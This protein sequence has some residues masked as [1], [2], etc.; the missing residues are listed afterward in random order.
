MS[1]VLC[2][3]HVNWDVTLHVDALPD[4]DGEARIRSQSQSG[5]GSAANVATALAT[6]DIPTSVLGSVGDDEHGRAARRKLTE[7]G[8]DTDQIMVVPDRPTT[9]KYLIVEATSDGQVMVFGNDGA[10]EAIGPTDIT[11]DIL[12]DVDHL[13][14][15]GQRPSTARAL[16]E[17][18]AT[19][20]IPISVD[21]GRRLADRDYEATLSAAD[22]VFLNGREADCLS[23]QPDISAGDAFDGATIVCKEGKDGA[24][25]YAGENTYQQEGYPVETVDTAGAGDAFAAGFL[26]VVLEGRTDGNIDYERALAVANACGALAT[27]V[28]GAQVE[29]GWRT[30]EQFL[31]D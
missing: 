2:A 8:V 18:A 3:G 13:H 27:T 21:P 29:V 7:C 31:P 14:L 4:P 1:R 28:E 6:L 5:G 23:I 26:A 20:G 19:I 24:T 10:N 30:V 9:V 17:Q 22:I 12:H 25:V 15:T 16:A 11:D